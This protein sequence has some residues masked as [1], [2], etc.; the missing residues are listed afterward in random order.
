MPAFVTGVI[1]SSCR[2]SSTGQQVIPRYRAYFVFGAGNVLED[3]LAGKNE[4]GMLTNVRQDGEGAAVIKAYK[5]KITQK[6]QKICVT[7]SVQAN[8]CRE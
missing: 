6:F 8:M 7:W 1:L 2:P 4:K 5:Q 3:H